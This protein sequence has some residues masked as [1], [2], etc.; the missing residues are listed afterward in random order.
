MKNKIKILLPVL[1]LFALVGCNSG[2]KKESGDK[3]PN[4]YKVEGV[5]YAHVS[6]PEVVD[7]GVFDYKT[8]VKTAEIE[9]SNTGDAVLSI[10]SA[11]VECECT[12]ILSLDSVVQPHQAGKMVVRLNMSE[13]LADTIYKSVHFFCNDPDRQIVDIKLRADCRM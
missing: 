4:F 1:L 7:M 9:Y 5:Q 12:E 13:Y 10:S 2:T 11:G 6:V 3:M 8:P